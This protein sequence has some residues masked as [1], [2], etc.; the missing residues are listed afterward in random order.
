MSDLFED[1]VMHVVIPNDL[2]RSQQAAYTGEPIG[3]E[4]AEVLWDTKTASDSDCDILLSCEDC[5]LSPHYWTIRESGKTRRP[6][7]CVMR[8]SEAMFP[9]LRQLLE[10]FTEGGFNADDD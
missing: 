8:R 2:A 1:D 9:A 10:R 6:A 7:L 3:R 5:P 4:Y